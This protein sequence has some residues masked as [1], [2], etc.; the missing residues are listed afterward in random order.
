MLL[1]LLPPPPRFSPSSPPPLLAVAGLPFHA[2]RDRPPPYLLCS[3]LETKPFLLPDVHSFTPHTR[4]PQRPPIV[5][6]L[7]HHPTPPFPTLEVHFF[8][9]TV[10][11]DVLA[12]MNIGLTIYLQRSFIFQRS[13]R[14]PT[15][16]LT[17]THIRNVH[18]LSCMKHLPFEP[19]QIC[20]IPAIPLQRHRETKHRGPTFEGAILLSQIICN[21]RDN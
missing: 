19:S 20:G 12:L 15:P 9:Y 5:R 13:P 8:L 10:S 21:G 3:R 16:R 18:T 11:R 2:S 7:P 6:P 17:R 14:Q 1:L 4:Q